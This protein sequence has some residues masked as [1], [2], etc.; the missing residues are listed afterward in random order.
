MIYRG[1]FVNDKPEGECQILM[2]NRQI[3]NGIAKNHSES[4]VHSKI[5]PDRIWKERLDL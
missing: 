2:K 5:Y 4:K 1:Y 3:W